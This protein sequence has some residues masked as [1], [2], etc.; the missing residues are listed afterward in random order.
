MKQWD[1]VS[2]KEYLRGTFT[3]LFILLFFVFSFWYRNNET[4][5]IKKHGVWTILSVTSKR[6]AAQA[7]YH[8]YYQFY[9]NNQIYRYHAIMST[10][11]GDLGK[12][13][14]MM[15]VPNEENTH[16]IYDV[17]PEWFKLDAP[18][19]GWKKHPTTKE[20]QNMLWENYKKKTS[21]NDVSNDVSQNQ[22]SEIEEDAVKEE[23]DVPNEMSDEKDRLN[24][25]M[26][27]NGI[28][29][30]VLFIIY[31]LRRKKIIRYIEE[32]GVWTILTI[33][34]K[35]ASE[36]SILHYEVSYTFQLNNQTYTGT[37]ALF[38][39][40]VKLGGNRFFMMVVPNEENKRRI[41][42]SVP[43]W[44]KLDVPPEGW[45]TFPITLDDRIRQ[46]RL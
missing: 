40:K 22:T 46:E 28:V 27:I 34:Q 11:R 3:F 14:F 18:P 7:G 38:K 33:I 15:V 4:N 44:F 24:R 9:L 31:V 32:H 35:K 16:R 25:I 42:D 20:L 1:E 6:K 5:Y 41:Y 39:K 36:K 19:D 8:V 37:N 21:E 43:E 45:K 26:F 30:S 2:N 10:K 12:R 29:C 13:F 17:V 23:A